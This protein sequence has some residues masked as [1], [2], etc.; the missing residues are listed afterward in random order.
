MGAA[1]PEALAAGG[2]GRREVGAEIEQVVL[3]AGERRSEIGAER[4]SRATPVPEAFS[5]STVPIAAKRGSDFG[6]RSPVA[7]ALVPSSPVRV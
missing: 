3:D 1:D 7:S 4:L 6:R 5:S 2:L